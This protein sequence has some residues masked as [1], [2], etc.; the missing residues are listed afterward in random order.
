LVSHRVEV[1]SLERGA[2]ASAVRRLDLESLA[3]LLGRDK[4]SG[5]AFV[6]GLATPLP[7]RRRW[8]RSPLELDGGWIGREG[9]RG[10]GGVQVEP[11]LQLG[12]PLLQSRDNRQDGRLGFWWNGVPERFRDWRVRAHTADTTKLLYKMFEPVNEHL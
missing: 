5:V 7:P 11:E 1:F 3:E 8:R 6:T 10:V 4:C 2:A 12:D 9:L